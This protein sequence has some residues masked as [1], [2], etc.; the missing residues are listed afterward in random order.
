MAGMALL[1][2]G[3]K[4][5]EKSF[6]GHFTPIVVGLSLGYFLPSQS[7]HACLEEKCSFV[8]FLSLSFFLLLL[9]RCLSKAKHVRT[10]GTLL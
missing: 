1:C 4:V 8:F 9:L 5:I 2:K 10:E 3:G 7:L 6:F